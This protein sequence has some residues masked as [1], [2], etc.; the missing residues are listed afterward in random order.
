M[1]EKREEDRWDELS[2][3]HRK[4]NLRTKTKNS[5]SS[6]T[7]EDNENCVDE[8]PIEIEAIQGEDYT[9]IIGG[10]LKIQIVCTDITSETTDAITS[11]ANNFL[12]HNA[13]AALLISEKGGP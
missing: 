4:Q 3:R 6:P 7:A 10:I 13:G 12:K 2:L 9:G 11:P 8:I 5:V 1:H